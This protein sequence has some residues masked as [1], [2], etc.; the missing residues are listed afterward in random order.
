PLQIDFPAN[1][2]T[3]SPTILATEQ[4]E[5]SSTL[6]DQLQTLA[7]QNHLTLNTVFQGAWALLLGR[8]SSESEV[9]F[10]VTV[11]GRP[12]ALPG[13]E[14]IVGLFI[15]TLPLR[16][17]LPADMTLIPWLHKLQGQMATINS[18]EHTALVDIQAWSDVPTNQP[19]FE[20]LFAFE[21][22]QRNSS[23][24][25]AS[26]ITVH[27][28]STGGG[29]T[30]Y[31]LAVVIVPG[32]TVSI[33]LIYDTSR[34]KGETISRMLDHLVTL[35]THLAENPSQSIATIN[36]LTSTEKH[37]L[38]VEWNQTNH[39]Y[40]KDRL[41][42]Q[43]VEVQAQDNP[44][45][46]ALVHESEKLTY[47]QL[48]RQANQ[49]ANYL[50]IRGA[51]PEQ[52][53]AVCM[54][55]SPQMIAVLLGI[56][57]T[58]AAYLP[59]DPAYP[60][61]RITFMVSDSDARMLVTEETL[62][63]LITG[64]ED[65]D[66]LKLVILDKDWGRIS[67][68]SDENP[69][70]QVDLQHLAYVIYTSGSTGRPKGVQIEHRGLLNLIYWHQQAFDV[71]AA[72]RATHLAGLGFDGAVWEVWP[73]LTAGATL[74]QPNDEIRVSPPDIQAWLIDQKITISFLPTPLAEGV[75]ALEWPTT[76][77][78]LR[79]LLTGGDKLNRYPPS[80]LPFKLINNYGPTESS[81]V[82]TSGLTPPEVTYHS[83]PSIGRPVSNTALYLLDQ[84]L[85]PVPQG[86]P[87]EL[88]IGG[89]SLARGYLSRPA[90]T[91]E[92]FIPN[93]F[94]IDNEQS[95]VDSDKAKTSVVNQSSRLYKTG[96]L[97]RYLANGEIEFLG[98][99][100]HQVQLRGF[101]IELGEIETTLSQHPDVQ[102][103]AVILY[104]GQG[105]NSITQKKQLVAYLTSPADS[106]PSSA[107]LRDFL[108]DSL[109]DY[110]IPAMF[111]VLPTMPLTPNGKLDRRALPLP[112]DLSYEGAETLI[113][114]KTPT[115]TLLASIWADVLELPVE[116][117]GIEN[118]FFEAG[119]H[120]LLAT[121]VISKVRSAFQV[122]L[123]LRTL[124]EQP[125]ITILATEVE[126]ARGQDVSLLPAITPIKRDG[127]LPLSFAQQRLWFLDQL[128]EDKT[129]YNIHYT[130]HLTGMLN[131]P[132]LEQS[133]Q[134]LRQR[135]ETLRTTFTTVDDT[136]A[137]LISSDETVVDPFLSIIDL[138]QAPNQDQVIEQHTL[139]EARY[140]FDLKESPLFRATLLQL[141]TLEY[142]LLLT[143]HH[144]ISDGW[145]M[146]I[147]FQELSSLYENLIAD[148]PSTLQPLPIQYADFAVWQRQWLNDTFLDKQLAYWKNQLHGA[149]PRLELPTDHL[150]P[151]IQ[152]FNGAKQS[153]MLSPALT[154]KLNQL[155][156]QEN[157]TLFMTLL[158][159]FKVLL[160]RYT[161]QTDIV[162][163]SPIANRNY[164]DIE[165]IVGFFINTLVLRT[166]I[167]GESTFR[168]VL[169][170]IRETALNAYA[171]QDLPFEKLVETLQPDRDLSYTPLFQVMFI[172]QN[173]PTQQL[174]FS[175]I[176][177]EY[178]EVYNNVAKF[179]LTL[180]MT[181][182]EN[183][184]K[185]T[186]EYNTDLFEETTINRMMRHFE[187]LLSAITAAPKTSI[188]QLTLLK[189][190]E[191][192][193]FLVTWNTPP[194][195]TP[196]VDT[197]HHLFEQ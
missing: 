39:I 184:L 145:S 99:A 60:P 151:P 147:L 62:T 97:V 192:N 126:K 63:H 178:L 122:D 109:S 185:T 58:G 54:N 9:L 67:Q 143:M 179:D 24:S 170:Q 93:P 76:E 16:V 37:Q 169:G 26:G 155:S 49:I 149:P 138:Q 14:S 74:Y 92:R 81:V 186:F 137:Q 172:L 32:S 31:P 4:R 193:Q 112:E 136:P 171:H 133:L 38:F 71:S 107:A 55:R 180:V 113:S 188:A 191:L 141:D 156:Q 50:Q 131:I 98:R 157:V 53:I 168:T 30:N 162:V 75:L 45:A 25:Q 135:H 140:L 119:G 144:I 190:T 103:V 194:L 106:A 165:N 163:G 77:T 128:E 46:L 181:E 1:D 121:Q 57:K 36:L 20:T 34:F 123:P 150:R 15:N 108:K 189:Q 21:N 116:Q 142:R 134:L 176:S 28:V 146:A 47:D 51:G 84:Y 120:S 8:Y 27:P 29:R 90:L 111:M 89:E 175:D 117:I 2:E 158:G 6:T 59:I 125:T 167:D 104:E 110:M 196:S 68:A 78:D 42:H 153:V 187:T 11:S 23:L 197:L 96:D 83:A 3:D 72:D 95:I 33:Q 48:N 56:F 82:A 130:I 69:I 64:H 52:I 129:A 166:N 161:Q 19:L 173:V 91:A 22:I 94:V 18:Y 35:L 101:R 118:D 66:S 79:M 43:L 80:D 88:Y 10:G 152:T 17:Q 174:G 160:Y 115:Q 65:N 127:P 114:P 44:D 61:D 87:G 124:F 85:Q 70:H 40:P 132:V 5:L 148:K 183:G 12:P 13:V 139:E 195:D 105:E 154:E 177:A 86:V 182:E 100:D 41:V 164:A 102:D 159:A 73:Y 7:Q